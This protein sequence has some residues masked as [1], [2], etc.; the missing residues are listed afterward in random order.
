MQKRKN[1][2]RPLLPFLPCGIAHETLCSRS[3][4]KNNTVLTIF[5]LDIKRISLP[6]IQ[7]TIPWFLKDWLGW[8]PNRT[9]DSTWFSA[10]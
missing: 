9:N 2:Q 10:N 4:K 5:R 1:W 3:W 7:R 8:N 6:K